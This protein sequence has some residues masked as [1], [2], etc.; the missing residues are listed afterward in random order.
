M[1]QFTVAMIEC[2]DQK[3]LKEESIYFGTRFGK[4]RAHDGGKFVI[5][6]A[7]SREVSFAYGKQ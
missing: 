2:H 6:G 4:T 7:G 3:Q 1:S 5:A